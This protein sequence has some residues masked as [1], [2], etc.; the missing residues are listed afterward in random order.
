M[1]TRKQMIFLVAAVVIGLLVTV[2]A[3]AATKFNKDLSFGIK[4]SSEVKNLQTFLS[5]QGHFKGVASGNFLSAT[6][7]AVKAFQKSKNLPVTGYVGPMTRA[8]IN[9]TSADALLSLTSL[10]GGE[11]IEV[12]NKQTLKWTSANYSSGNVKINIIKKVASNP[13]QYELVRSVSDKTLN[14][15]S[16]TWIPAKS[17]I[18]SDIFVEIG[19][20]DSQNAC[21][22]AVT[23]SSLAVV[24]S[25]KYANTA[26]VFDAL[27]KADNK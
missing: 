8:A 13:N 2:T 5:Q 23:T 24:D 12:G 4:N 19:C 21:R 15:G 17:D 18:G 22:S 14:D 26:S 20:K 3:Q 25:N 16:A 10:K 27:E 7:E 6:T 9:N 11:K 1:N